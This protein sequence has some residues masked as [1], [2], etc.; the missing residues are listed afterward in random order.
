MTM[1]FSRRGFLRAAAGTAAGTALLGPLASPGGGS[2]SAAERQPGALGVPG[3]LEVPGAALYYEMHGS[4]PLMLMVPGAAG[5]ADSFRMVTEYLAA[6]YTVVIYDR[7]GFSRSQ[8]RGPQDYQHR[9]QTDADDARRMIEH[10]SD[11]PATVFGNSSGAQ[12][13]LEV[14]TH[15]PAVVRTLVPHEPAAVRQLPDGREWVSFFFGTYDLY[16]QAGTAPAQQQFAEQILTV[17]D[18]QS[19]PPSPGNGEPILVN[20]TY[21]FERELRQYPVVDLDLDVLKALAGRIVPAAGVESRGYPCHEVTARLARK[22]DRE[23]IELPGGHLGF[24]SQP[25]EF[26][27]QVVQGLVRTGS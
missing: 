8:L 4:G 22:L 6:N 27:R 13:A 14:L 16:R 17:S 1:K 9:L 25:A 23:L 12:V 10:L 11:E 20:T 3:I 21:W 5:S 26:A 24:L 7:R 19:L 2:A 15:Y 18:R